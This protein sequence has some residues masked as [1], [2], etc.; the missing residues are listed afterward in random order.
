[1]QKYSV[2]MSVY[3]KE[4]PEYLRLSINSILN[5][6][7]PPDEIIIVKDGILTSEL[8]SVLEKYLMHNPIFNVVGYKENKGLGFALNYGLNYCRNELVARM[9]SDDIARQD[10]CEKQL[11]E[12]EKNSSIEIIGGD[13]AEFIDS[14]D[15]I[16]A[17]RKVP[18]SD[19]EIKEYMK[20][21]CPLNHMTVMFKKSVVIN[22]G[23]YQDWFWN[24]DYYLWIRMMKQGCIFANTGDVLVNVR[25]DADM[26]LRRGGIKYFDSEVRLQKYMLKNHIIGYRTYIE[27]VGKRIIVQILLPNRIRGWVFRKFARK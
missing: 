5:Q 26:Y 3:N 13:I 12:F 18:T 6:T 23:S 21:R 2:L 7:I 11:K 1:M 27:N 8:D 19:S 14:P 20:T 22:A 25:I 15:N 24:E 4:K 10:R 17:Y 16:V 9:D